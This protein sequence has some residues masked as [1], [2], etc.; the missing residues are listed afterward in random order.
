MIGRGNAT[1]EG[2]ERAG[3]AGVEGAYR[4]YHRAIARN[5][6]HDKVVAA[7]RLRVSP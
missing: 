6:I 2:L 1:M 3:S 7:G 4:W 5:V